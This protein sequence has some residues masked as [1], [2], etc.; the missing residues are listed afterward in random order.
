MANCMNNIETSIIGKVPLSIFLIDESIK[1]K[2]IRILNQL[3]Y[4]DKS[5]NNQKD[6]SCILR[7][8]ICRFLHIHLYKNDYS[9]MP[10]KTIS[11]DDILSLLLLLALNN[12]S[13]TTF[14]MSTIEISIQLKNENPAQ[15]IY[16]L[17]NIVISQM[18]THLPKYISEFITADM[19]LEVFKL[20]INNLPES[21][22]IIKKENFIM[23]PT[24]LLNSQTNITIDKTLYNALSPKII[25]EQEKKKVILPQDINHIQYVEADLT[26]NIT[27]PNITIPNNMATIIDE[28]PEIMV[29]FDEATQ[30]IQYYY[31]DKASGTLS[32]IPLNDDSILIDKNKLENLL[33]TT[34]IS[35]ES[36]D[37]IVDKISASKSN[38]IAETNITTI[39]LET[40]NTWIIIG[41][42]FG[43]LLLIIIIGIIYYTKINADA[44]F[45]D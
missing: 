16:D 17:G 9:N 33:K 41:T 42:I 28:N 36:I 7:A 12:L 32:D 6:D 14:D 8:I 2:V 5:C 37:K 34:N 39:K 30:Q 24:D 18:M 3:N 35:I 15:N 26:P 45:N 40:N 25:P 11:N 22:N 29:G 31:Y 13:I 10:K 19:R 21:T 20:F 27:V 4:I 43:L 1:S 38:S 44:K 23:L